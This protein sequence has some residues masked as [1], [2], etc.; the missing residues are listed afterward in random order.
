MTSSVASD[1]SAENEVNM[2]RQHMVVVAACRYLSELWI[3]SAERREVQREGIWIQDLDLGGGMLSVE[4]SWRD[5][6]L[7]VDCLSL[8][9]R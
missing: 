1:K 4:E 5:E 9:W 6:I 3:F 2:S 8:I 7:N